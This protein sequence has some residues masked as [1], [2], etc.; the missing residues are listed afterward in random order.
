M[1]DRGFLY[2]DGV[3]ET[4]RSYQGKIFRLQDHITRLFGSAEAIA[5][6]V[7]Y[8]P[9]EIKKILFQTLE[10]NRLQE[11]YLRITVSRGIAPPGL[12]IPRSPRP[13]V[14]VMAR[15]VHTFQPSRDPGGIS[16]ALVRTRKPPAASLSPQIKS[17]NYLP[18]IIARAEAAD[19]GAQE[20]I[21]LNQEGFL[22]EGA[23]SN[24][25]MVRS[26]QLLTPAPDCGI[27]NGITRLIVL[28]LAR[29]MRIPCEEGLYPPSLI[30]ESD[31]CFLTNTMLELM[32]VLRIC[33][34]TADGKDH[35]IGTGKAGA[36]TA[37]LR[38]AYQKLVLEG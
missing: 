3:F 36:L 14:V 29:K 32:P 8:T 23:V 16:I 25:F 37:R 35:Q 22:C 1:H 20:G 27:F 31:E 19:A 13:T 11:A 2:G 21:L 28:D 12:D 30:A 4:L 34:F 17:L 38:S 15:P 24:L 9:E 5:L 33:R 26:G 6:P 10:A 7:S 18:N